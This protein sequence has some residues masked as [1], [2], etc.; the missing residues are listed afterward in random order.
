M[1]IPDL[2]QA[3]GLLAVLSLP[4]GARAQPIA[5]AAVPAQKATTGMTAAPSPVVTAA[6]NRLRRVTVGYQNGINTSADLHDATI[7]LAEARIRSATAWN[8]SEGVSHNLETIV[9]QRQQLLSLAETQFKAGILSTGDLNKARAALAEARVRSGLYTLVTIREQDL[10]Q[11]R[12]LY[13]NGAG[14]AQAMD[15]A[16]A[17]LQ[18][19]QR[20][21]QESQKNNDK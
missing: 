8:Q 16:A 5:Q 4:L 18:E 19:A 3:I 12:S 7:A 11:A 17:A 21:F 1:N 14:S 13:R 20:R 6:E 10:A 9:T 15:E 2:R